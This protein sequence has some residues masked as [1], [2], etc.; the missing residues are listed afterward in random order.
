M[1]VVSH[2]FVK[3]A[4]LGRIQSGE[5]G[6]GDLIPAE[7][8]LAVHYGCARATVNRALRELAEEGLVL[9]KRKGGTR[10]RQMP[11]RQAKLAIPVIREQIES[12]GAVYRHHTI[13]REV[14]VPDEVS[15]KKLNLREDISAAYIE[16]LHLADNAPYAFERRWVNVDAIPDFLNV[17]LAAVSANEWL[18]RSV[19]FSLGSLSFCAIKADALIAKSLGCAVDA[20][21]FSMNRTTWLDD[22]L[23]TDMELLFREGYI[24]QS[25]L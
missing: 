8:D 18:V 4:I 20:A 15:R 7:T 13:T 24:L 16:T 22:R 21:I 3:G 25:V 9:R 19:P 23:I 5:W 11:V 12:A 1:A 2:R 6:L 10:V 14:R 17:D